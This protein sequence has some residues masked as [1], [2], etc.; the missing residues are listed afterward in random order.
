MFIMEEFMLENML[1]YFNWTKLSKFKC[2]HIFV[3]YMVVFKQIYI[4]TFVFYIRLVYRLS[5]FMFS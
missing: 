4:L 5:K 2:T 3:S 1:T